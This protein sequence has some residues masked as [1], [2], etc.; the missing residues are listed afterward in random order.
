[1]TR[2]T[3]L[4]LV[5]ALSLPGCGVVWG[6]RVAI[7]TDETQPDNACWLLHVVEDVVAD[8]ESGRPT[9]K[10]SGEQPKWPQGYSGWRAGSEVEVRNGVGQV[11]LRTPGRYWMCPTPAT[12]YT[13]PLS[14]WVIGE[15]K[16]CAN[17]ELGGGPD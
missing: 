5:V 3:V 7:A 1:L 4:S 13:Q 17:C 2:R 11:V 10:R 14:D 12:D 16:P 6:E 8:P 9:I 15:V